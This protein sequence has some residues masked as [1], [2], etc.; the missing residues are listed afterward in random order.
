M[1][2]SILVWALIPIQHSRVVVAWSAHEI[3]SGG[4]YGS[5]ACVG[6]IDP[7]HSV[8]VLLN[9]LYES[10]DEIDMCRTIENEAL[11]RVVDLLF[12]LANVA[13]L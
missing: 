9:V 12:V 8:D 1:V 2:K 5:V 10:L 7:N 6:G 3:V 4:A 11:N 13:H